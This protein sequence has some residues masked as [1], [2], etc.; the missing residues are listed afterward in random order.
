MSRLLTLLGAAG[1]L[2]LLVIT[3]YLVVYLFLMTAP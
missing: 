1:L 3:M 2:G